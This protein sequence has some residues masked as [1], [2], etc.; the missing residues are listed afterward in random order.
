M[1]GAMRWWTVLT[2][3]SLGAYAPPAAA[4]SESL[5]AAAELTGVTTGMA[6]ACKQR[7]RP[8]LYAFRDLMDRKK[9][10]GPER[11][12]LVNLVSKSHDRSFATQHKPG[13]MSCDEVKTQVQG[14]IQRLKRAK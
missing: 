12:R 3:G 14:T 13:A 9:I 8:V 11:K 2:L 5:R 1:R 7:T 6:A 4:Q 10:Q